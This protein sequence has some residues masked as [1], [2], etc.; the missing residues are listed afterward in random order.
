MPF[1]CSSGTSAAPK[2]VV[3]ARG[4]G[5]AP[6]PPPPPAAEENPRTDDTACRA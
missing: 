6:P 1:F 5:P 4:A 2:C 3:R